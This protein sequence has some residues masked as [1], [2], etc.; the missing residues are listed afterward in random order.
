MKMNKIPLVGLDAQ[1]QQIK[2]EI[3]AAIKK[4]IASSQFVGG[5][6]RSLF[7]REFAAYCETEAC[8]GV[9]N[10]TDAIHLALRALGIGPGDEVIIPVN[11]FIA[12]AEAISSA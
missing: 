3:D 7:E 10:G 11:T 12:T 2:P 8:V 9:G 6:E 4:V 1:Y 5:E